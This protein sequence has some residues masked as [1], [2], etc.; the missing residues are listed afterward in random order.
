MAMSAV[1]TVPILV[2][3]WVIKQESKLLPIEF[4]AVVLSVPFLGSEFLVFS[5]F[6]TN[7]LW[8]SLVRNEMISNQTLANLGNISVFCGL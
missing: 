8:R 7:S 2:I 4:P 5:L 1:S 3:V 6:T